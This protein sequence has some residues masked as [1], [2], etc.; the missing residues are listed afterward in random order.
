M[1]I[2]IKLLLRAGSILFPIPETEEGASRLPIYLFSYS[3]NWLFEKKQSFGEERR[4]EWDVSWLWKQF[5]RSWSTIRDSHFSL[6]PISLPAAWRLSVRFSSLHVCI[7]RGRDEG[8]PQR[9]LPEL[10]SLFIPSLL[11]WCPSPPPP[12]PWFL[13]QG[14][15]PKTLSLPEEALGSPTKDT[16]PPTPISLLKIREQMDK[17]YL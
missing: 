10:M 5:S 15:F 13:P 16:S 2:R 8:I 4:R 12:P 14:S 17:G 7:C 6:G 9:R 11:N 3:L 1:C